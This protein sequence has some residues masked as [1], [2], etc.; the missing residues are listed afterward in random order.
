[1][2]HRHY[3]HTQHLAL[4]PSFLIPF[5]IIIG[6]IIVAIAVYA[7]LPKGP[8]RG[9]GDASLVRGIDSTDHVFG[10]PT[11]KVII[12]E[13]ADFDCTYCKTFNET[14]HQ[15]IANE[16]ATG[17]VAWVFRH[18]PLLEIHP[19]ALSHARAAECV[20]KVAGDDMFWKFETALFDNQPV[21]PANY[22]ALAKGVGITGDAFA[23]CY[24]NAA[25][26][27]STVQPKILADRQNAL[28]IG[29]KGTPYS[30]ML[31]TGKEPVI[32]NGNYPYEEMRQMVNQAL[33]N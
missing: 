6:G 2:D 32:I 25:G 12:V 17:N 31:V 28:D 20:A 5:A 21:D 9:V 7:S 19:N 29:A 10:N 23:Q 27:S 11:A 30:V 13:Y 8:V 16:G 33:G 15:L 1:M 26:V 4:K 22:G 14:M 24:A 3:H 18:Y